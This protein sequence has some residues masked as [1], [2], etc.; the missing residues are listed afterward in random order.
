MTDTTW[1]ALA[2]PPLPHEVL[3]SLFG[4]P[5]LELVTPP[6]RTQD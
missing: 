5:R 4:D 2:L 1:R 6:E 3:S